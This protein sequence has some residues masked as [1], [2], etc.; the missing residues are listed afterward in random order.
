[1]LYGWY[2]QGKSKSTIAFVNVSSWNDKHFALRRKVHL[3]AHL[4]FGRFRSLQ[5]ISWNYSANSTSGRTRLSPSSQTATDERQL[6]ARL[7]R[8]SVWSVGGQP[9][10]G[11]KLSSHAVV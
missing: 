9:D 2:G 11:A 5:I 6:H 10:V 8:W 7:S 1:M 4:L 3:T